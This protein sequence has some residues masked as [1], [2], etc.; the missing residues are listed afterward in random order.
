ML[1]VSEGVCRLATAVC[2]N[3][4][5]LNRRMGHGTYV[6]VDRSHERLGPAQ[7]ADA[8]ASGKDLRQAVKAQD[9]TDLWLLKLECEVRLR[10]RGI[11]EVEVVVR[12][13]CSS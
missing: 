8:D 11:A 3:F 6:H 1:C 7:K 10:A 2:R 5:Q 12:V 4:E 9:A 13:V